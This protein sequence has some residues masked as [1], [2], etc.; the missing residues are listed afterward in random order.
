MKKK[1]DIVQRRH[2]DYLRRKGLKVGRV[3]EGRLMRPRAKEVKRVLELCKNFGNPHEW[4]GVVE[5]NLSEPYLFDW[6][7]GLYTEAGLPMMKSTARDLSK[8]KAEP[9]DDMWLE[10][11]KDYA[12]QRAGQEIVIVSGTMKENLVKVVRGTLEEHPDIGVEK[13]AQSIFNGYKDIELWQARRI[14]QTE[15]MIG[16]AAASDMAAQTLSVNFL[17]QWCIS[18]V[19]NTRESHEVMDGVIV[20]QNERFVL[21]DCEMNYPHEVGAPAGEIINCACTCIRLPM[22]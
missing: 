9:D 4:A 6:Y 2:Q 3:Y 13:F 5:G 22:I 1:I 16:L 10:E 17:K 15:T 7:K 11:L 21:K 19:G 14:A 8:G 12:E 20:G 18:G